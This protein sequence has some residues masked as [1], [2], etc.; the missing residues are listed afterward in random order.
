MVKGSWILNFLQQ[1]L[2]VLLV[3]LNVFNKEGEKYVYVFEAYS[4]LN[5]HAMFGE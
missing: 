2:V 5:L 4:I 1:E 3:K